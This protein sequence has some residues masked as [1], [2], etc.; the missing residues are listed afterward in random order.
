MIA[1]VL[2]RGYGEVA[3][4][5][6]CSDVRP[7]T[8]LC[9]RVTFSTERRS[10]AGVYTSMKLIVSDRRSVERGLVV[11]STYSVI[12]I[13]DPDKPPA[14]V[15][16]TSGLHRVLHLAFHDAE[17]AASLVTPPDIV[18]M[19]E[20]HAEQIRA[21]VEEELAHVQAMVVHCEQGMSRSPAVAA[22]IARSLGLDEKPFFARY[23]PNTYVYKLVAGLI[24]ASKDQAGGAA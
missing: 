21:F 9:H 24:R 10:A 11:R 1:G 13:H 20:A 19:T 3:P 6:T 2:S 7:L 15:P 8:P 18:P 14:A 12:S 22:A 23:M 16:R 5:P 4:R 17:P